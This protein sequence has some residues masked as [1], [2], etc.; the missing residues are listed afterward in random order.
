[1]VYLFI[2]CV[3]CMGCSDMHFIQMNYFSFLFSCFTFSNTC[4]VCVV[5][6]LCSKYIL[7]YSTIL[8]R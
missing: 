4:V 5:Y 7:Y 8:I 1:M 2:V 3:V 6:L